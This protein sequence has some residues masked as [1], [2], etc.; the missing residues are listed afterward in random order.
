MHGETVRPNLRDNKSFCHA[1]SVPYGKPNPCAVVLPGEGEPN[2]R[3]K[4]QHLIIYA[5]FADNPAIA[6][7][8]SANT[9][10][11]IA[12]TSAV[13]ATSGVAACLTQIP[14]KAQTSTSG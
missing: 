5:F 10:N 6:H 3:D 1:G 13:V 7:R 4:V 2:L 11:R 12:A 8:P 14:T 9:A